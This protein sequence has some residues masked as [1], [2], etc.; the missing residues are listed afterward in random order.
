MDPMSLTPKKSLGQNFLQDGNIARKIVQAFHLSADDH[1]M[2]IGPGKGILTG[3]ILPCVKR[4]TAVE[5][6]SRCVDF[7]RDRFGS[8]SNLEILYDDFLKM[9]LECSEKIR[10]VG[11]I[12]YYLT[13]PIIFRVMDHRHCVQDLTLLIQKEVAERINAQPRTKS[14][15]I[16]SVMSQAFADVSLLLYVPCTVFSPR[17]RVES[18]LVRWKFT[19]S[20]E[21]NIKNIEFFRHIVRTAFGQRRKMLRNSLQHYSGLSAACAEDFT[22]R[23]EQLSVAEWI[24]LSNELYKANL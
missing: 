2:E 12:P 14:Y 20:R 17:P 3:L 22:R 15:G 16:L 9:N 11:N 23:P 7:L 4:L 10:I 13:S 21:K 19:D 18:A 24:S 1:V 5:I 8:S 6:D